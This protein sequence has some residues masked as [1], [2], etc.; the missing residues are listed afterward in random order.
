[1]GGRGAEPHAPGPVLTQHPAVPHPQRDRR[2]PRR[3]RRPHAAAALVSKVQ[4]QVRRS[5]EAR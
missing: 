1:M 2:Q 3:P 5:L 4:V